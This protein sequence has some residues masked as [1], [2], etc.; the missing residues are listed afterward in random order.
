MRCRAARSTSTFCLDGT[1]SSAADGAAPNGVDVGLRHVG[2][3]ATAIRSTEAPLRAAG[4]PGGTSWCK[5]GPLYPEEVILMEVGRVAIAAG[6][7][8]AAL[9]A[10]WWHLAPDVVDENEARAAPAGVARKKVRGLASDRLDA[11]SSKA[12]LS[13]VDE[14]EAAQEQRNDVLHARW[15]LRGGDAMRPV[16]EFLS[17]S[18]SGRVAYL[19]EWEREAKVSSD[20][21]RQPSQSLDL[22]EPHGLDELKHLERRLSRAE[23]VAVQWH[24]RIA[25]MRE[26]GS[27]DGWRG[28][29]EA[30]RGPQPLP[31]GALTG[32]RAED[33]L[34][35]FLT[36]SPDQQ[37]AADTE[38]G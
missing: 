6:R 20:W 38:Q 14:V 7:L 31:P 34:R 9:G 11:A 23:D 27:P 2:T 15:L 19:E 17:L 16:G 18:P 21:R 35:A 13:F 36:R 28:P 26:T 29:L 12:L 33:A 32:Q 8:D 4:R 22:V 25:S 24:F 30:R 10:L 37:S 1:H 5:G 3:S